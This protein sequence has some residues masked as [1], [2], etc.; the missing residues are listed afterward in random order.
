MDEIIRGVI[1][2]IGLGLF[3]GF[4]SLI[5]HL[6]GMFRS[7]PKNKIE[8][9]PEPDIEL[10]PQPI[11]PLYSAVGLLIA[12]IAVSNL[13]VSRHRPSVALAVGLSVLVARV[14]PQNMEV[15]RSLRTENSTHQ[16]LRTEKS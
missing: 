14:S 13:L 1:G 8:I 12:G 11:P 3:A 7:R 2:A 4:I 15:A 6:I 16:E 5:A 10:E 9:E